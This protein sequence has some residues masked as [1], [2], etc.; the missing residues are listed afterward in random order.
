MYASWVV[1]DAAITFANAA[2]PFS[3]TIGLIVCPSGRFAFPKYSA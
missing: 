1:G 3:T 2:F